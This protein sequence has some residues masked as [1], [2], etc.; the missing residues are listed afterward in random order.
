MF[1]EDSNVTLFS[2]GSTEFF[3]IDFTVSAVNFYSDVINK[4]V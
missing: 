1:P 2:L 4:F 3:I